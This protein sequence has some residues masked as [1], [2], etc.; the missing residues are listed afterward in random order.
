MLPSILAKQLQR[1]IDD[2]IETTFPMANEPFRGSLEE[3]LR[4][5]DS[6]YH[7]PYVAVR[8]PFRTA[9]KMPENFEGV[10]PKFLPYVHQQKAFDRLT[11]EDG[12][13]TL[14]ATGTG[15]GKTE[16]FLYPI[17][18][19]C[20]RHVGE[21]GIKALIIYPMNALA[22]DQSKRI[23]KLI[24]NNPNLRNKVTVGM[25]VGGEEEHPFRTMGKENVITD[26][27]TMLNYPPD[28][29]LTN[30]KMLDYLLVRPK[31]AALWQD[32][33]PETLKYIAVDELHTFD[34]AQGTDLAC[35][36]RRLKSRLH[37]FGGYLCCVGTSATMGSKDDG[38]K[39]LEY[40][41]EIFGEP[42]EEDA[43][44]TE[45]RLSPEEYY[46]GIE[47][48]DFSLPNE[49]QIDTLIRLV[50]S[51][52]EQEY[53][54][55]A[56]E[57]W[58][59]EHN[60]DVLSDES[61]LALGEKLNHNS[62]MQSM[63][64]LMRGKYHQIS[65]VIEELKT[66]YPVLSELTDPTA[67]VNALLALISH[68]RTGSV[69]NL[70]PFLDV[71]VQLWIRELRRMAAKVSDK[72]IEY[73][74]YSD[75]ST[76]TA[77]NYLPVINCRDCGAT[78]WVSLLDGRMNAQIKSPEAF[79]NKFFDSRSK[80]TI[81]MMYPQMSEAI[82]GH[83]TEGRICPKCMHVKVGREGSDLCEDCGTK[84]I[85]IAMP[86][87]KKAAG[88]RQYVCPFCGSHRGIS[89]L[90]LRSATEI[91]A[92]LSQMFASHFNDDKKAL[93][94]SDN[95]QDASHRAAFFN[96][97]TWKFAVRCA[98]QTYANDGGA[99]LS[100]I[101]FKSGFME[102]WHQK[103]SDEEFVSCFIAPNMVW[104]SAYENMVK[105]RK[106]KN[107]A[108]SRQLLY[109]IERRLS[110]EILLE[111]GVT[112]RIGRTLEKSCCS[113]IAYDNDEI[114]NIARRVFE[115]SANEIGLFQKTGETQY[116]K[117]V[118][119]VLNIMRQNGAFADSVFNTFIEK[120]GNDYL[121]TNS[122][123]KWMPGQQSGRNMPHFPATQK[124][125]GKGSN[126]FDTCWSTKY[127]DYLY[128]CCEDEFIELHNVKL[129][130]KI[131][132]EELA[133]AQM[134]SNISSHGDVEIYGINE[135]NI[136]V[137]NKVAH[138]SC[139]ICGTHEYV[140][141]SN[142]SLWQDSP[143]KR[144]I[145]GGSI[146]SDADVT[147][148]YYNRLFNSG[149]IF[150]INA[151]EHTG[152]LERGE[153]EILESDFKRSSEDHRLWDPNV[154]S[155]TPTLEMGIDIG[156]LS[157]VVLCSMPPA[158][159]QF[160]QRAGRA[161]RKDGNALIMVVANN[162]P[163]DLYFYADPLDMM[164]GS[165]STP[166][167]FL[168]A[169]AV[170]ERQFVAFCMDSWVKTKIS[171]DSIPRSV[172]SCLGYIDSQPKNKFPFNFIHYVQ[173]HLT[174][175]INTFISLFEQYLD[176]T[177]REEL[178][179]FAKGGKNQERSMTSVFLAA[180]SERKR[181][182]D[183]IVDKVRILKDL[184]IELRSKPQDSSYEEEIKELESEKYGLIAVLRKINKKP[185]FEF[186]S[187]EG[188]LPNYAFPEAGVVLK[189]ILTRKED[190]EES[191][192]DKA[193]KLSRSCYEYNRAASSAISE[194]APQ[195]S[196]YVGGRKL[197]IDQ[198]DLTSAKTET[199]RLCPNCSHAEP[200]KTLGSSPACPKCGSPAWADAGQVRKMLKVQMVYST[201]DYSKSFVGDE[202]EDRTTKFFSKQLLVE[203]DDADIESAYE[204]DND[205]FNFGYEFVKKAVLREINFGEVDIT[206][207]R[208]TVSGVEDFRKGFKICKHC[209]KIQISGSKKPNHTNYC[210][211]KRG[212]NLSGADDYEECLF[213]YREFITEALRILIPETTMLSSTERTESFTA[214]FMMGMREHFGNVDHLRATVCEEPI[215]DE[216]N[217]RK[218]YLVVYDSVPGGTGYLKQ[219]MHK[220]MAF[221]EVLKKALDVIENC[222]CTDGCYH[223]LYGYRI[224][225]NN[226]SI[227]KSSAS[228]ILKTILNAK[229]SVKK[230]QT[231]GEISVNP[232]FDSELE[233]KFIEGLGRM[234]NDSRQIKY[235]KTI[236]NG[237]EGYV[238]NVNDDS[239]EIEPQ[240]I[241]D[242]ADG[243]AI[244]SKPDFIIRPIS[245]QKKL[246]VAVFTDGFTYHEN[247]S[248]DD[249]L[250]REAI[251][252]SGRYHVWSL[253]WKD[254]QT[255]YQEQDDYYTDTLAVSSM[256]SGKVYQ[257]S[258]DAA[259]ASKLH[260]DIIGSMEMLMCYLDSEYSSEMF[261]A[262]AV[263]ISRSLL[264]M[265]AASDNSAFTAWEK[266][267]NR[268][269]EET[270]LSP[271]S[272]SFGN[273]VFGRWQ[274]GGDK[275]CVTILA[276]INK[277]KIK[278]DSITVCAV[279][280]DRM[281]FRTSVFE[282]D[283]NG[284]LLFTNLMQ[285]NDAF[286]AVS[287]TGLDQ[288]TYYA[289]PQVE[290]EMV[291]DLQTG[292]K[293]SAKWSKIIS[294]YLLDDTSKD[295]AQKLCDANIA[296]PEEDDIGYEIEENGEVVVT[297]EFSW[298][299]KRIAFILSDLS[300]SVSKA[301]ELGWTVITENDEIDIS[302]FGGEV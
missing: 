216:S 21:R 109:D 245:K 113:T 193:R 235:S 199:W 237:K 28:I 271:H 195:N 218:R 134:I 49:E 69:E 53:L 257:A 43:V 284:F 57:S 295:Y 219:L 298:P 234:G 123:L 60:D 128:A 182:R 68:A 74:S 107:D 146:V 80:D 14:I 162:R 139:N 280:D 164:E 187:D 177:A 188:L 156:D 230:V 66:H 19:Y 8:M 86:E 34:G 103:L 98:I 92:S 186:L 205:E 104:M 289:L 105:N 132:F 82:S 75:I 229:D 302:V 7:E 251:R 189:A 267:V 239:W 25:Y 11:G 6:V 227:S 168:R 262:H 65:Y 206:G 263:A 1:G 223:C 293:H 269:I 287:M 148:D 120:G 183:S 96:A 260:P 99:G 136:T 160:L 20:F 225:Q 233:R 131:I 31:D 46:D 250:K 17:I 171:E 180:F 248:A 10:K 101:E 220:D 175:L 266:D 174:Y 246:P 259:G 116:V 12:Q 140:A 207:D 51:N 62:F 198:V 157:T 16:C 87:V 39:I 228:F 79:Y 26:H 153:R 292:N 111:F 196:F 9:D 222:S 94:F 73:A 30:Y 281:P 76:D 167:I 213:L 50:D 301:R 145:C 55:A 18:E 300:D 226:G 93:T 159:S 161:G 296:P 114:Q 117:M 2:Y 84:M 242:N 149:D 285:F 130:S 247:I 209:G 137:T 77:K 243:V 290:A 283:W 276:G 27:E 236:I 61:R 144:S 254:V 178:R 212:L 268:I 244:T 255:V 270:G 169:S 100:L 181:Q 279:L 155:C 40:A 127:I 172:G 141:E 48:T 63:V 22:N 208:L 59:A 33:T 35:L 165:V 147:L 78:G 170:L 97:R 176:T 201:M 238:L 152:I 291:S 83:V 261:E 184:I 143:C 173:T 232:L 264:N 110:Y 297:T 64:T 24:Y 194:F 102:Y 125:T 217:I 126:S 249:T 151:R 54:K 299:E 67:A 91:S 71:Q 121:L 210:K 240:V 288:L 154:L 3:M 273:T 166:K 135:E 202:S 277:D 211:V 252:R 122:H 106:L 37:I 231:I 118:L 224:S 258:V 241:L 85:D 58:V 192:S 44:V 95:V 115:R 108:L 200:R 56:Y 4:T 38:K 282:K 274:P 89:M 278:T 129:L 150:R 36:L 45:D 256:P 15:S 265:K 52:D 32:N 70:R 203:V 179:R 133:K 215:S 221:L 124:M 112:S 253:S 23:A 5:K 275:S 41:S 185:M 190:V 142:L 158:Q 163:H 47:V 29:L 81:V 204:I 214:A 90:G 272:F 286:I 138:L 72:K 88:G 13:S 294:Q 197:T 119:G 191:T 42:F